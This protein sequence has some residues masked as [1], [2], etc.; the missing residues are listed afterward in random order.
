MNQPDKDA[1]DR[2]RDL[3]LRLESEKVDISK[4]FLRQIARGE[5]PFCAYPWKRLD[6]TLPDNSTKICSDFPTRLP[7]FNWPSTEDFHSE[8]NMWNHPFMQH[9]RSA[10]ETDEEVPYCKLCVKTNKRSHVNLAERD[11]A[12]KSTVELYRKVIIAADAAGRKTNVADNPF[13]VGSSPNKSTTFS[14]VGQS[15]QLYRLVL[16]KYNF[17][18]LNNVLLVGAGSA[19]MSVF[20]AES[21]RSLSIVDPSKTRLSRCRELLARA[22]LDA[23][24]VAD[25]ALSLKQ[26][27][28]RD[29]DGV[30]IDGRALNASLPHAMFAE[31]RRI[32]KS[33][34]L[35]HV[36]LSPALGAALQEFGRLNSCDASKQSTAAI[37][38]AEEIR[39]SILRGPDC[40]SAGGFLTSATAKHWMRRLG[41]AVDTAIG[42]N[43]VKLGNKLDTG[44]ILAGEDSLCDALRT[45]KRPRIEPDS[46][47]DE[48]FLSF[49]A[50]PLPL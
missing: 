11:L 1:L 17:T 26:F 50:T 21:C 35:I 42:I 4:E 9:L 30:W 47:F 28:D 44:A 32:L 2:I 22:S 20:L 29:F 13:G 19:P 33:D 3:N 48:A 16:N 12:R 24:M 37:A 18:N 27:N 46:I 39:A 45:Y 31:V 23:I 41:F 5:R 40:D 43:I 38:R 36:H 15:N 34:G 8:K 7:T 49:N 10:R 6:V 25:A 14:A